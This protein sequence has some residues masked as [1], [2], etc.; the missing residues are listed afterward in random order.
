MNGYSNLFINGMLQ[1]ASLYTLN[2]T[3]LAIESTGD[4]ILERTPLA[5]EI[6]QL[7][8]QIVP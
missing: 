3:G 8:A 1:E 4:T 5:V 2:T 7:T 6:V